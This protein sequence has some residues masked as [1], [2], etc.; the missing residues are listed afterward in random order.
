MYM[1]YV[2]WYR[3]YFYISYVLYNDYLVGSVDFLDIFRFVVDK[4][5]FIFFMVDDFDFIKNI[6]VVRN[7]FF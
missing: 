2:N 6:L 4:N 7:Y 3:I 1:I 5:I